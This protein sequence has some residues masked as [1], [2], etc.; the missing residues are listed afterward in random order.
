MQSIRQYVTVL[1][2]PKWEGYAE[3]VQWGGLTEPRA[4]GKNKR[5]PGLEE[6]CV[7]E[8]LIH[9]NQVQGGVELKRKPMGQR[10]EERGRVPDF[11][12]RLA[13]RSKEELEVLVS[14][15]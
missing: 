4:T 8:P 5:S 10:P 13:R 3:T 11:L 2:K 6:G 7:F 9:Q 12:W 15:G 14:Q 1:I